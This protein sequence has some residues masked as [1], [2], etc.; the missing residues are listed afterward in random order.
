MTPTACP[1]DV[2]FVGRANIDLTTHVPHRASPGRTTFG[3]P[4]TTRPG[5]KS[6]NQAITTAQ[7][8]G[9]ACLIANIGSDSWGHQ[10]HTALTQAG[11]DTRYLTHIPNTAT[12]AAVIEVTPDGESYITLALSPATELTTHDI[13]QATT[14]LDT[15]AIVVQLDLPA[16]PVTTLLHQR[17]AP[18]VIGNLVPHANLHP[19]LLRHLDLLVVNHHEATTILRTNTTN[20]LHAATALQQLGPR[21]V[22]VTAGPDGAAYIYPRGSGTIPAPAVPVIDT[23]GAGDAFLGA[24]A[25]DLTRQTPLPDAITTA[26]HIA[27]QTIQHSGANTTLP[28]TS[29]N[30][31]TPPQT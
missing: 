25:L 12:S 26:T 22:V 31:P 14:I 30:P 2:T 5:G 29:H 23:T 21:A 1:F 15:R 20:P 18:I 10:I 9:R 27:A 13:R 28:M 11:V 3:S 19:N 16:E 7:R 17:P 24:L 6:L 8:G 4:L